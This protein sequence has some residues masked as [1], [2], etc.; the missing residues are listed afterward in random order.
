MIK[1]NPPKEPSMD[2]ILQAIKGV[3]SGDKDAYQEQGEQEDEDILE[4]TE[5]ADDVPPFHTG[6][7]TAHAPVDK[8]SCAS[9]T[10]YRKDIS[11]EEN[12]SILEDIDAVLKSI[13]S[14]PLPSGPYDRD[15][16]TTYASSADVGPSLKEQEEENAIPKSTTASKQEETPPSKNSAAASIYEGSIHLAENPSFSFPH[17]SPA[18]HTPVYHKEEQNLENGYTGTLSEK[19][20]SPSFISEGSATASRQAMKKLLS[21]IPKPHIHS[22]A[23]RSG[24]TLEELV[25]EALQPYLAEWLDKNLP[26]L[27]HQ[28]VEKEIKR[29]V[30]QEND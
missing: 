27:V 22:P 16:G 5:M 19:K 3:I 14:A 9:Q 11:Q 28:I 23:S 1:E 30:P 15:A 6:E 20:P 17:T 21:K 25:I 24:T 7:E 29:L 26:T 4:L 12:R 13:N 2:E 18:A 10:M 8:E